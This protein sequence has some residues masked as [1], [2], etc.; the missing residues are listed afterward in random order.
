M[1]VGANKG[2]KVVSY[3][4]ELNE[5]IGMPTKLR[6]VGVTKDHIAPLSALAIADFCHPN[7]PKPVSEDDFRKIYESAL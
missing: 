2:N 6:E 7:N 3:I 1:G 4:F 5:K